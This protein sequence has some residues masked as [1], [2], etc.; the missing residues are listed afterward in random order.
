M[1]S[2]SNPPGPKTERKL[3]KRT[4]ALMKGEEAPSHTL[5][6]ELDRLFAQHR[7]RIYRLC[8][9]MVKDEARA[10]ELV[11]ETLLT[12]YRKI[13][14]FDGNARFG[15]W[16]YG[17][18]RNL[19]MNAI[20][21]HEE[22]LTTD[23]V[24]EAEDGVLDAIGKLRQVERT[25]WVLTAAKRVLSSEEQEAVYLRYVEGMPQDAITEMLGLEGSGAR[26][27]L[28]RCRRKL[29]RELRD[30]LEQ[31]GHGTSFIRTRS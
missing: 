25:E 29:G 5:S 20:R 9:K 13:P 2:S 14:D 21:K 3:L 24:I 4:R 11:Q 12:A 16:I 27:L 8:L 1:M 15:T 23:G 18:A 6:T 28:Q 10:E 26:G 7:V 22:L 30:Q 19:C 31:M 17:I